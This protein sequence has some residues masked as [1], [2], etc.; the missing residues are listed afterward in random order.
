M[1]KFL[2]PD[3]S[4]GHCKKTIETT[5]KSLEAAATLDFD[6]AQRSVEIVS[7]APVADILAALNSAGYPATTG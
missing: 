3:M 6:M 7:A 2:I 4:C 1:T 5:V